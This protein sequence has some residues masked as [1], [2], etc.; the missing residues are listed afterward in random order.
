MLFGRYQFTCR[1]TEDALLPPYKGSTFRGA[2]GGA[3]KKVVCA[4]REKD[5]SRCLLAARCVYARVFENV[6]PPLRRPLPSGR[7]SPSLCHRTSRHYPNP[8]C[9]RRSL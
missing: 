9:R 4:V 5:C 8:L 6:A 3:L 7:S 1:F 2:F